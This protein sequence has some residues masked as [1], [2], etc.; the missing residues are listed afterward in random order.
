MPLIGQKGKTESKFG[1]AACD[2][3]H[4]WMRHRNEWVNDDRP[5]LLCGLPTKG[6]VDD[7]IG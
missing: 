7:A 6:S 1:R 5:I 3:L 4:T 2:W